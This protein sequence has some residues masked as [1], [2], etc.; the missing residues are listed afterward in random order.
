MKKLVFWGGIL[1]LALMSF[2]PS[3]ASAMGIEAAVGI[4]MQE[5][6]GDIGYKGASLSVENELK[7][8]TT[9]KVFGRV[10]IDM[11]LVFPNIYLMATPMKF[12]GNGSKNTNFTFGDKTFVGNV[13]F[14]SSLK[15]DHYDLALYYGIPFLKTATLGMF[16][17]EVGL[18]ARIIDGRAEINQP[19]TGI[20][21]S[22]SFTLPVPMIYLG[23]QFN[24]V[25][26]LALEGEAR[27][28]AYSSNYY[29]DF[30]GR[31]KVQPFGPV[32]AAGGYR[33]EAVKIDNS[34]VKAKTTF[35]G[36]FL[37]LGVAF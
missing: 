11:P 6:S 2:T 27:G 35:K 25:K 32:F 33:Y 28:I 18:N 15:L 4:W 17:V 34:D 21:E 26:F 12:D 19:S 13:P 22:E 5:P 1:C 7:Y 8:D 14:S 10:K 30:I 29:Y 9:S 3:N 31:L 36:P 20:T 16:N 24:P 37:E 23:A